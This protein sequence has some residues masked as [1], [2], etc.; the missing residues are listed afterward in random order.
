MPVEVHN[1]SKS[2]YHFLIKELAEEFKGQ[3]EYLEEDTEKYITFA[4]L[5]KK[6]YDN[7]KTTTYKIKFIDSCR[8]MKSK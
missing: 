3:F 7:G 2:A 5:I 6:K 1:G 4:V 8:F